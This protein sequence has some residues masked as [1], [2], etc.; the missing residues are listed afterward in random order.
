MVTAPAELARPPAGAEARPVDGTRAG[1]AE[2][3]ITRQF[4]LFVGA[5]YLAYLLINLANIVDSFDFM[6]SWWALGA[7]IVVFGSGLAIGVAGATG[8]ARGIRLTTTAAAVMFLGAVLLTDIAWTGAHTTNGAGLWYATFPGLVAV[9]LGLQPGL[10]PI[11]YLAVV[12]GAVIICNSPVKVDANAVG[13]PADIAFAFAY[14]MPYVCATIIGVRTARLLDRTRDET[15]RIAA[16]TAAAQ[17]RSVE[18]ARFDAL[19]HDGVMATLLGAARMGATEDV[20]ALARRTLDDLAEI[21]APPA[22]VDHIPAISAARQLRAALTDVD[23]TV[24]P[25]IVLPAVPDDVVYPIGVVQT[26]GAAMGEALRNSIRHAAAV[27]HEVTATLGDD[28]IEVSVADDGRGFDTRSVAPHRLGIAVS[29]VGRMRQI[30]GGDARVVST[31][32]RGTDVT[33]T[34]RR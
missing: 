34:W 17:A 23:D 33:I 26:I 12:S 32:G 30:D 14:S 16:E 4:A 25:Q 6:A 1:D 7:P 21:A 8:S 19:T 24:R 13:R 2:Q 3:R 27:S 31:P 18:R 28:S 5:G 22:G 15:Y 29:I 10:R 11:I 9:A 20:K